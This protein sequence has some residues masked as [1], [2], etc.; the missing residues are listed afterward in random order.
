LVWNY[1][2]LEMAY[3]VYVSDSD[4]TAA[5]GVSTGQVFAISYTV[6]F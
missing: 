5:G 2:D 4:T 1:F 3:G 6:D